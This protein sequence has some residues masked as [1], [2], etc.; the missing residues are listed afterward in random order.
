MEVKEVVLI[1][2]SFQDRRSTGFKAG[3]Y[4][5]CSLQDRPIALDEEGRR[6]VR[7]RRGIPI[8]RTTGIME[9]S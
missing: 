3:K 4:R 2:V 7:R 9:I 5:G 6:R 8:R 1:P